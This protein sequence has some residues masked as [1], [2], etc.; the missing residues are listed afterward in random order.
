[1][2]NSKPRVLIVAS[3]YPPDPGGPALHANKQFE[4]FDR[5]GFKVGLVV[6][7]WY[8]K[9]PIG[10]RHLIFFFKILAKIWR[11]DLVYM[12]DAVGAGLPA[13]IAAKIFRKR[14][15]VRIG[16][17]LAWE[18]KVDR[19]KTD[20]S[21]NEWYTAGYNFNDRFYK[22]SRWLLR[23][24]NKIV[25]PSPLLSNLYER[26]YG[27]GPEKVQ[28]IPN[29]IPEITKNLIVNQKRT[30]VYASRLVAYKNLRFVLRVLSK[31]FPLNNDIK[32][33]IM[34]D[35]P[36]KASLI[37]FAKTLKIE[38]QVVFTGLVDQ[39]KV[40]EETA[41]C[42][43]TIG[44]ALTEFNPNYILQ[45]LS[46]GKPFLISKENGFPFEVPDGF[47]FDPRDESE[48]ESR[49]NSFLTV[50]GYTKALN[51]ARSIDFKMSW[52]DVM[53]SNLNLIRQL[54]NGQK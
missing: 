46:F 26:Y 16:G 30:I 52:D 38:G 1:M 36:E 8:K 21:M 19:N 34:G 6:L 22:L 43:F 15:I 25:V 37:K 49:I 3:I 12:H 40:F 50:D 39:S 53:I 33:I 32:F 18:R 42:L 14:S 10:L 17:D 2:E 27:I 54:L 48:L 9:W 11:Y 5:M 4:Y 24:V 47:L 28:V 23:R 45:S 13:L 7:S 20:L 44:P 51:Q 31:I 29:P 41:I 35:G